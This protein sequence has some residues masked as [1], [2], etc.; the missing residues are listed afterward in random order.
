MTFEERKAHVRAVMQA[1]ADDFRANWPARIG[2]AICFFLR[3]TLAGVGLGF[4]LLVLLLEVFPGT[5][6]GL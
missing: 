4:V 2:M 5:G 3:S 1:D 6:S